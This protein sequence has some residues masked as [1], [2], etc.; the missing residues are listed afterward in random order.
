MHDLQGTKRWVGGDK[1]KVISGNWK[2]FKANH[3]GKSTWRWLNGHV[4][5]DHP[6]AN[7]KSHSKLWLLIL[8]FKKN[9]C[10]MYQQIDWL[11]HVQEDLIFTI[12]DSLSSPWHSI[13]QGNRWF[14]C[15]HIQFVALLCDIPGA[16]RIVCIKIGCTAT[17]RVKY[18]QCCLLYS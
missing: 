16:W 17:I 18:L 2:L 3:E 12:F 7:R 6:L 10:G 5:S 13:S 11:N 8:S 9:N 4:Q 14:G 15:S 1:Q